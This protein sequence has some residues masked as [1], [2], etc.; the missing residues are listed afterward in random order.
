MSPHELSEDQQGQVQGAAI[1]LG[2]SQTVHKSR[3][4]I[5]SSPANEDWE[6]LVNKKQDMSWQCV[7]AA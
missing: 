7:P 5:E 1:G 4:L 3:E 2:Q 6:V